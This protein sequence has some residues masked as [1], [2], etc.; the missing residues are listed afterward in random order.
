MVR[1]GIVARPHGVRGAVAITLDNPASE[2]LLGIGHVHLGGDRR[3][4]E[5]RRSARGKSGQII[6]ELEGIDSIESAETL[7]GLEVLLEEDQLPPL[8]EDEY[9]HRDL[10]GLQAVRPDG[11]PLGRVREIVDT[12]DVPVLVVAHGKEEHFVPFTRRY[13]PEVSIAEGRVVVD[14]PEVMG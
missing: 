6:L 7:R 4:F 9:W 3:R 2:S 1:V 13:V 5:V 10:L 11:T 14:P 8:G 12:A